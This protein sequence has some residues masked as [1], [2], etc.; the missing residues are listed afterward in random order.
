MVNL[1]RLNRYLNHGAI[2]CNY[3]LISSIVLC[4]TAHSF[5]KATHSVKYQQRGGS[6]DGLFKEGTT[7]DKQ[8]SLL[9]RRWGT[10]ALVSCQ[11]IVCYVRHRT[12]PSGN[13]AED[14]TVEK[15]P[16]ASRVRSVRINLTITGIGIEN[17]IE[18]N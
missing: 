15:N 8:S 6:R 10:A 1:A 14:H 11:K 7:V 9:H 4:D 13:M 12:E 17:R 2:S 5:E 3:S 18:K 16:G